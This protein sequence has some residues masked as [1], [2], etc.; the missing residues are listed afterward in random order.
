MPVLCPLLA[1]G[2]SLLARTI[3]A[4]IT[5]SSPYIK[6]VWQLSNA[7]TIIYITDQITMIRMTLPC[8]INDIDFNIAKLGLYSILLTAAVESNP[9]CIVGVQKMLSFT[10]M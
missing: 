1:S 8:K 5:V 3:R 7:V 2:R 4:A 9:L 6:I 10:V